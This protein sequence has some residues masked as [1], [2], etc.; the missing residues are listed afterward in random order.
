MKQNN[1]IEESES[2]NECPF[3]PIWE[4]F[5]ESKKSPN[6]LTNSDLQELEVLYNNLEELENDKIQDVIE[7][8]RGKSKEEG[9]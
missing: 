9:E 8:L 7:K 6:C 1:Q 3:N 4:E 5:Q 2:T